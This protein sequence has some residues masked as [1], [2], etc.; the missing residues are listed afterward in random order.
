MIEYPKLKFV[1][2]GSIGWFHLDD[3]TE[4]GSSLKG[5]FKIASDLPAYDSQKE[6]FLEEI[7]MEDPNFV[8]A[9][10]QIGLINFKRSNFGK[11]EEYLDKAYRICI[12]L[13]PENFHGMIPWDIESNHSFLLSLYY[14]GRTEMAIKKYREAMISLNAVLMYNPSDELCARLEIIHNSL[15]LG[16]YNRIIA[17]GKIYLQDQRVES[18]YGLVLAY[19]RKGNLV[20]ARNAFNEAYEFNAEVAEHISLLDIDYLEEFIE[21]TDDD[22]YS[23]ALIY[24]IDNEFFWVDK[25]IKNFVISNIDRLK[26]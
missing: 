17:L 16:D 26:Q 14:L 19:F 2:D 11:A 9:Y 18:Y 21:N 25:A 7:I 10:F 15:L 1:V 4:E 24:I 5:K 13:L 20:A 23:D 3:D 12:S 6:E 8:D 22:V